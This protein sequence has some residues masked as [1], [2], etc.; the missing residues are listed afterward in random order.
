MLRT[1]GQAVFVI[2]F[3]IL[4]I[5]NVHL[6]RELTE[7]RRAPLPPADPF[8]AGE[9]LPRFTARDRTDKVVALGGP[10]QKENVMVLFAPGC[11]ACDVVLDQIAARPRPNVTVVSLLPQRQSAAEAR[12]MAGGVPVYFVDH[13][14]RSPL[15][16]RARVVPQILR[17]DAGGKIADVCRSYSEC[18]AAPGS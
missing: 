10:L 15:A 2:L 16:P 13:I 12:K 3:V 7:A 5:S 9:M 17:L 4:A 1:A 18:L 11:K 14:Q 6:R 8:R